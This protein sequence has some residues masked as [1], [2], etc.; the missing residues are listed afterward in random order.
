MRQLDYYSSYVRRLVADSV[1][2]LVEG[3]VDR[4]LRVDVQAQRLQ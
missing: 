2:Y 4:I 1:L 3:V